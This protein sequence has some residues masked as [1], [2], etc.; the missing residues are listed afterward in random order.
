MTASQE[1]KTRPV[2][3]AQRALL[4]FNPQAGDAAA[5]PEELLEIISLM[6]FWNFVPE[7]HIVTTESETAAVVRGALRRGVRLVVAAGGDGTIESTAQA[8]VDT[9]AVLGIL[10]KGTRNNLALSLGI[11]QD[12][13]AAVELLRRGRILRMDVGR[14]VCGDSSAWFLETSSI[15][16]LPAIYPAADDIQHGNLARITELLSTLVTY[17]PAS[18]RLTLDGGAQTDTQGYL[19]LIANAPYFGANIQV[20]P[21]ISFQDGWLDVFLFPF[22]SKLDLIGYAATQIA[23]GGAED[24][25]I[26]HYRVKRAQIEA[27]PAMHVTADGTSLGVGPLAAEIHS[28][29][30]R[31]ISGLESTAQGEQP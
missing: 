19:V 6:Q 9:D 28:N 11:P 21:F 12:L 23:V 17:Q 10:P 31:V 15:G 26:V 2:A 18:L 30:L 24:S 20:S 27:D 1:P 7:V 16:L 14:A 13:G 25:R 5:S 4:V 29:G 3:R 8:L 22:L